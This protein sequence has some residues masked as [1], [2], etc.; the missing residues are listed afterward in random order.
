M[1]EKLVSVIVPVYNA[2]RFLPYCLDSIVGQQYSNLDIIL[3]DDGSTDA[4]GTICDAYAARDARVRVIHNS[5]GG[6]AAAQNTGLDQAKGEYIAFCDN[7]DILSRNNIRVLVDALEATHADMSKGR[8]TQFGVSQIHDIVE[9]AAQHTCKASLTV[10]SEPLRQYQ[11]VFSKALRILGGKGA[12]ARYFNEANW[13]RIYTK[14]CWEGIRFPEGMYAQ[15]VMVAGELYARMH[16]VVDVDASLYYWL[17]TPGSVTHSKR[18]FA[19]F[20]DNFQAG[21]V[22]FLYA[23]EHGITPLRSYYTL[24]GSLHLEMKAKDI[25]RAENR[26]QYQHDRMSAKSAL[27]KIG[28]KDR[29]VC[30]LVSRVRLMEKFVYDN[31]VHGMR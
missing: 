27:S 19:F 15:D 4:S 16:K 13:C 9:I 8:W 30:W 28:A 1:A 31:K 10:F 17:Q 26:Q 29:F 24:T 6:I 12:E 20:H 22:N 18:N 14:A 11:T 25:Q 21:L 3:V 7:D 5:N 2:Q 23:C